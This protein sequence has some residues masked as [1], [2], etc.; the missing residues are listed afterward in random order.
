MSALKLRR[1]A[2]LL[3]V[4]ALLAA[5]AA[6]ILPNVGE[7]QAATT[8]PSSAAPVAAIDIGSL[9]GNE[10]EPDENEPDE[11]AGK[12]TVTRASGISPLVLIGLV[13]LAVGTGGYAAIRIR[14]LWLRLRG[15]GSN[16]RARL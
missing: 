14:R 16:M 1:V 12:Q 9:F 6:L 7:A 15:W 8:A 3:A 10:N 4:G 13:V 11:G 5:P 2:V